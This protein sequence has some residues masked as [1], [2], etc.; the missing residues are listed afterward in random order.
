MV[1]KSTISYSVENN[2]VSFCLQLKMNSVQKFTEDDLPFFSALLLGNT[3][4]K[5]DQEVNLSEEVLTL[6]LCVISENPKQRI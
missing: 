3:Q 6:Q 1:D 5:T 2:K 4:S